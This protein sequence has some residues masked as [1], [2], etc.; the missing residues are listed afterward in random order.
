[1]ARPAEFSFPMP[2]SPSDS[3]GLTTGGG[4]ADPASLAALAE[5][6]AAAAG[7]V[8]RAGAP[9]P[10]GAGRG[11]DALA[12]EA[13]STATDLVTA[14][15]KASEQHIVRALRAARPEDGVLGEEGAAADGRSGIRWVIDP[16]DG[17]VNFVLGLPFHAVSIA[18]QRDGQTVAG[19]VHDVSSGDTYVAALGL[20]AFLNGRGLR[21]PRPVPLSE[22]VLGTGFAYDAARR[23]RQGAVLAAVL[24]RV[25]NIRRFGS[26]ALDLCLVADGRLGAYYEYGISE[27]D[28]AAGLLIATESGAIAS[29]LRGRPA[30]PPFVAAAGPMAAPELFELLEGVDADRVG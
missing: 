30:A 20:G 27:W 10:D 11:E 17:T 1:M 16:I 29:G 26:A 5:R 25:A 7:D 2:S 15:D 4:G 9:G 21:G 28:V 13:K 18:A 12:I 8:V 3:A 19:A 6:V 14:V 23:G 24:P 22:A